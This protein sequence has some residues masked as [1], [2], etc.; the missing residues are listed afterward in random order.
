M[1]ASRAGLILAL[2]GM[3]LLAAPAVARA[4]TPPYSPDSPWNTPVGTAPEVGLVGPELGLGGP[5]G[6]QLTSDPSQ[7]TY[8]VYVAGEG[9]P[10]VTVRT[11][12]WF[13]RVEGPDGGSLRNVRRGVARVP[14]PAGAEAARGYDAQIIVIDE[15][16]GDEWNLSEVSR[17][18]D[19]LEARNVGRYNVAWSGVP[20]RAADGDPWWLR[21]AGVP[22]LAGL[23]R[24]CEISRGRIGH[25]LAFAFD[26]VNARHV[27]PATK[28]DGLREWT[29][30]PAT[31][32]PLGARHGLPEG[33]RLQLDPAISQEQISEQWGCSG[34]CLTIAKALQEY[35]MFVIDYGGRPKLMVEY[36]GTAGWNGTITAETVSPIPLTAFREVRPR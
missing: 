3:L 24:P 35:G 6:R 19:G 30:W 31:L 22:Y 15:R 16:T 28:S 4:C 20:P 11:R 7:Y 36:E 1:A 10:K 26:R 21:G 12:D 33:T 29:L 13:S 8:P 17:T 2:A 14:L 23:V 25:A 5:S 18:E 9:T 34:A 27:R 32:A